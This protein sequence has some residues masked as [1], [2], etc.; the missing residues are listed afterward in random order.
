MLFG[1]GNP[2]AEQVQIGGVMPMLN[3]IFEQR[4]SKLDSQ[5][6]RTLGNFEAA[7]GAFLAACDNFERL[8][9]EPDMENV[10]FTTKTTYL[11]DLKVSYVTALRRIVNSS[12]MPEGGETTYHRYQSQLEWLQRMINEI[13]RVNKTFKPVLDTYSRHLER[14]KFSFANLERLTSELGGEVGFYSGDFRR[15]SELKDKIDA[16]IGSLNELQSIGE[17]LAGASEGQIDTAKYDARKEVLRSEIEKRSAEV[18]QIESSASEARKQISIMFS[19]I[20]KAARKHDHLSLSKVKL[21]SYIEDPGRTIMRYDESYS[22]FISQVESLKKEIEMGKV[23]VKNSD[24]VQAAIRG[25][26]D[27]SIKKAEARISEG[28][29]LSAPARKEIKGMEDEL[30]EIAAFEKTKSESV[31]RK[32][33]LEAMAKDLNTECVSLKTEI[34]RMFD[35]FYKKRLQIKLDA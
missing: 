3:S 5:A 22:D 14:F 28:E 23:Q 27:G 7:K 11:K 10:Y 1:R 24:E 33:S 21:S 6:S 13:L 8:Q 19:S 26:L 4:M 31:A 16:L 12:E 2:K 29:G 15:Y 20:D 35:E 17:E 25:I 30:K 9:V 18:R 32:A 34:E